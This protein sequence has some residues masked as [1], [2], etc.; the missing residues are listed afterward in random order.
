MPISFSYLTVYIHV[1]FCFTGC[2]N[3]SAIF[4]FSPFFFSRQ[5]GLCDEPS[6][7]PSRGRERNDIND[8]QTR[9]DG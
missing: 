9:K 1:F 8:T 2:I 4:L 6:L 3:A 5:K 7:S